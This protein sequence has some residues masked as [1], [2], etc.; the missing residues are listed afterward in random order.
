MVEYR[1]SLCS[2]LSKWLESQDTHPDIADFIINGLRSWFHSPNGT[3]PFFHTSTHTMYDTLTSHLQL[4]WFAVL[5]GYLSSELTKQQQLHFQAIGSRRTGHRWTVNLIRQ[6][7][8]IL[9]NIWKHRNSVL[10]SNDRISQ[11]SGL[12][13]LQLAISAEHAIGLATLPALYQS[14]F[15]TPLDTIL[16]STT[17]NQK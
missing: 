13:Q 17:S 2:N 1:D 8:S 3:E 4:S 7:W 10:H 14:Y 11:L 6:L 12:A 15:Q 5:C 9:H 16:S